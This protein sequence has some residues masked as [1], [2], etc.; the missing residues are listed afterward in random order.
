MLRDSPNHRRPPRCCNTEAPADCLS[1]EHGRNPRSKALQKSSLEGRHTPSP[2][3]H[4]QALPRVKAPPA[5]LVKAKFSANSLE[6]S[7]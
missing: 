7:T 6:L 5:E 2:N 1:I 4:E 3:H